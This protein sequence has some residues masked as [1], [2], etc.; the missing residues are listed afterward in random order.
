QRKEDIPLLVNY[1]VAKFNKKIGKKIDTVSKETLNALQEYHWPGNVR[2]LESVIERAVITSQ[3]SAL[4]VLDR[5]ETFRKKGELVAQDVKALA[6]LEHDHILQVL[7]KT[8]WRIEGKN[9]AAVLLGLNA[10]TLRARIRKYGILR[11]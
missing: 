2:E 4:Q 3:G 8:G 7:Q 11:Q 9:G 1:F 5:L 6:E 10:S